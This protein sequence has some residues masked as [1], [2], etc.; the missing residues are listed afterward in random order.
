[1]DEIHLEELS[2][3]MMQEKMDDAFCR[4]MQK[5]IKAGKEHTPTVVSKAPGHPK[6]KSHVDR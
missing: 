6:S 1:M 2:V 3:R 4:A 5:A